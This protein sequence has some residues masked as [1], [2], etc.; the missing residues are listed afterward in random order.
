MATKPRSDAE[1]QAT[2]DAVRRHGSVAGAARAL[3]VNISTMGARWQGARE[4]AKR[5]GIR[6]PDTPKPGQH[7]TAPPETLNVT[8][9]KA[10]LSKRTHERVKNLNDLIRV[11]AIDATEWE[12]ERWV[13]NKWEMGSVPPVVGNDKDG[14]TRSSD[15]PVVT[16]LYQVK[17]W[18]KRRIAIAATRAEIAALIADAK[19]QIPARRIVL[20]KK[21][22]SGNLLEPSI[23]DL[24]V[25]KLAWAKETGWENYDGRI[26]EKVFE[27]ALAALLA[28]TDSFRCERILF[29]IGNDLLHSDTKQGT[30]TGGTPLDMDSRYHKSFA[31]VRKMMTRAI[32]QLRSIAPV[33]VVVVPGN[34]DTLSAWHSALIVCAAF[35]TAMFR[36]MRGSNMIDCT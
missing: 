14:W 12:V 34:H 20:I 10:E 35:A 17:A 5:K 26:A 29:P 22:G 30:T 1:M 33:H 15:Q 3:G 9:D 4:W 19:K 18:L 27:E 25:G 16:E 21:T 32:D 24:H 28:R 8:G 23:P 2:L 11:C 13:C 31:I 7:T 36:G 6:L